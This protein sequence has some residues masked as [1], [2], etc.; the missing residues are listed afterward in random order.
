MA[1][2]RGNVKGYGVED[3]YVVC[4]ADILF[5]AS[6]CRVCF[7]EMYRRV[8]R[9]FTDRLPSDRRMTLAIATK[10]D[11]RAAQIPKHGVLTSIV[12]SSH[13]TTQKCR[14][15]T[16]HPT[17]YCPTVGPVKRERY[18]A[19]PHVKERKRNFRRRS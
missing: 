2:A 17:Q 10:E 16:V 6:G 14:S 11:H 7:G 13:Y 15:K 3:H 18:S 1:M 19:H 5:R 8:K 12:W 4:D 9:P